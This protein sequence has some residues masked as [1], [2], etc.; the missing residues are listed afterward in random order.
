LVLAGGDGFGSEAVNEHI[1]REGLSS[2]VARLRQVDAG[3]L[4]KLY[5][6]A[7]VFLF[8]SLEEGFGLPVLEAMSY[9]LPAVLSN[10]SSLP[11]VGGDAALYADPLSPEDIAAKVRQAAEDSA[12]RERM[13]Q[14]GIARAREFTW[15]RTARLTLQVYEEVL[16]ENS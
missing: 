11:E 10:T 16:R 12:L 8:P 2:R 3:K 14:A 1:R 15:E 9:G 7:D 6:A 5:Q 13:I 4:A